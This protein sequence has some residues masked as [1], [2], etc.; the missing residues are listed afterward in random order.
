MAAAVM[1]AVMAGGG[2]IGN[3]DEAAALR[4]DKCPVND[5]Q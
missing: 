2:M 4:P 5:R 3:G 1:A